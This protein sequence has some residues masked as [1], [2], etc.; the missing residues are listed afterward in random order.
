MPGMDGIEFCRRV[1]CQPAFADLPIVMLS[2]MPEPM[3][4]A[5]S[6]TAFFRKPASFEDLLRTVDSLIAERLPTVARAYRYPEAAPSRWQPVDS[7]CW[8]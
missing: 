1:R 6:W 2:G 5:P 3:G 7:K 8:P 4:A